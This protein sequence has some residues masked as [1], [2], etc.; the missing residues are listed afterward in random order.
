[1]L[2]VEEGGGGLNITIKGEIFSNIN[3]NDDS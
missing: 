1:M 2:S 3:R